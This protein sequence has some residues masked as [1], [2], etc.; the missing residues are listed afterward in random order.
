ME[1]LIICF[2]EISLS[3]PEALWLGATPSR[4]AVAGGTGSQG[5]SPQAAWPQ[6]EPSGEVVGAV[7]PS[8][9]PSWLWPLAWSLGSAGLRLSAPSP[10][11]GLWPP[12]LPPAQVPPLLLPP[13]LHSWEALPVLSL[14][15]WPSCAGNRGRSQLIAGPLL[16][17]A[18]GSS[19]ATPGPHGSSVELWLFLKT[20]GFRIPLCET[21]IA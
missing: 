13:L 4:E 3:L 18:L 10:P 20:C 5:P 12:P 16:P 1:C 21:P 6:A 17:R 8:L 7:G 14:A 11:R 19:S 2:K 9:G 15:P